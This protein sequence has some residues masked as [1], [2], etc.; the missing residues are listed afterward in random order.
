MPTIESETATRRSPVA[1]GAI[2]TSPFQ[3]PP[4]KAAVSESELQSRSQMTVPAPINSSVAVPA[5]CGV[6]F[7]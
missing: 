6:G 3:T 4:L 7:S 2:E 1:A 5:K